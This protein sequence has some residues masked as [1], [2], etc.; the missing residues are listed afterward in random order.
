MPSFVH[1]EFVQGAIDTIVALADRNRGALI[2]RNHPDFCSFKAT[3]DTLTMFL[4]DYKKSVHEKD[5]EITPTSTEVMEI[6]PDKK[7]IVA[8]CAQN[9]GPKDVLFSPPTQPTN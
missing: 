3:Y 4:E 6:E 7:A 8:R 1:Q 5:E 9:S 2:A